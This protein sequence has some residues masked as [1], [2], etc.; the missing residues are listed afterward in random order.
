MEL[1]VGSV[2]VCVSERERERERGTRQMLCRMI[3]NREYI[4]YY[5]N[6]GKGLLITN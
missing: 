5:R 3:P 4:G 1:A 6:M 2:C